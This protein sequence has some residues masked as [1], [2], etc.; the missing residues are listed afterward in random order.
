MWGGLS[1]GS[2]GVGLEV[3]R[4]TDPSRPYA[5]LPGPDDVLDVRTWRGAEGRP[6]Q[7]VIWYPATDVGGSKPFRYGDLVALTASELGEEYATP[8]ALSAAS[9][10]LRPGPL[11][12]YVDGESV[13]DDELRVALAVPLLSVLEAPRAAGIFP[14]VLMVHYVGHRVLAEYLASHG[15]VVAAIPLLGSSPAWQNRGE[16]GSALGGP[17]R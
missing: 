15:Y 9:E 14:L 10:Q 13:T 17:T 12:P 1:P 4:F 8:A 3:L 6:I 7:V 16:G 2:F 5:P 11:G